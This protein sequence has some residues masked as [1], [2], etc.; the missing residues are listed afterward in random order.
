MEPIDKVR[1]RAPLVFNPQI[2][3]LEEEEK[4]LI[5]VL[6]LSLLNPTKFWE[7]VRPMV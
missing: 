4:N 2:L 3:Q 7:E 5:H 6:E 1:P